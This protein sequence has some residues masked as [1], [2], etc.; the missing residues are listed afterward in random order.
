MAKNRKFFQVK[1]KKYF[2][3]EKKEIFF[4]QKCFLSSKAS[5][6]GANLEN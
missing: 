2:E 4:F 1:K 3:N 5:F 6:T